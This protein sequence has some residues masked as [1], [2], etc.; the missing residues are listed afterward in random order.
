MSNIGRTNPTP[1]SESTSDITSAMNTLNAVV[2]SDCQ[3]LR[4]AEISRASSGLLEAARRAAGDPAQTDLLVEAMLGGESSELRKASRQA[5]EGVTDL[6]AQRALR[7]DEIMSKLD[8]AWHVGFG[9][10]QGVPDN[11][12]ELIAELKTFTDDPS[13]VDRMLESVLQRREFAHSIALALRTTCLPGKQSEFRNI[14]EQK[15]GGSH[16]VFDRDNLAYL[17]LALDPESLEAQKLLIR[18]LNEGSR[19]FSG[20]F[21]ANVIM[22]LSDCKDPVAVDLLLAKAL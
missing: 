8:G 3:T 4:G 1:P 14:I 11:H 22:A 19:S 7:V 12:E 9:I 15:I 13:F 5:L 20:H 2:K 18:L 6:R 21:E 16:E 17:P 10:I